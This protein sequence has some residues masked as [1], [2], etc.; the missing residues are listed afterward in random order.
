MQNKFRQEN[1]DNML[2]GAVKTV[3]HA[4][5][6]VL[7]KEYRKRMNISPGTQVMLSEKDG[8]LTIEVA[9]PKCKLCGATEHI[10]EKLSV[11]EECIKKI[12]E[13]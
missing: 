1:G 9:T 12:K 13:Y 11:C 5:R 3:D 2:Y 4:G 10:N 7:P 6:V 8:K